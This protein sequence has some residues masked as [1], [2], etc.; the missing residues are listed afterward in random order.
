MESISDTIIQFEL[1]A[2]PD[3]CL[4]I[5]LWSHI[6]SLGTFSKRSDSVT[7]SVQSCSDPDGPLEWVWTCEL[8]HMLTRNQGP[9]EE[10]VKFLCVCFKRHQ[11][12]ATQCVKREHLFFQPCTESW[13]ALP[14]FWAW[15]Y[16]LNNEWLMLDY[17]RWIRT[18]ISRLCRTFLNHP[19]SP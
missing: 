18:F 1:R 16:I 12:A 6:I 10:Y 9:S 3:K 8:V 17:D 13:P 11:A 15:A 14:F 4:P 2:L 5:F 7:A 19:D